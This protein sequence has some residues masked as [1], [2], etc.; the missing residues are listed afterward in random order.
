MDDD[1]KIPAE[2]A[3]GGRII[4]RTRAQRYIFAGGLVLFAILAILLA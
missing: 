2:K 3:R 4:L 1:R